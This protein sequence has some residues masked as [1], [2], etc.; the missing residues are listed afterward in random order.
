VVVFHDVTDVRALD[1]VRREFVA[2][3]SHEFRTPLSILHG[4]LETLLDGADSDPAIRQMSLRAMSRSCQRLSLLIDDLLTISRLEGKARILE[5]AACDLR[6]RFSQ[7]LEQ[8]RP[9]LAERQAETHID[10][11]DDASQVEADALRIEQVFLN[12]VGN[13]IRH[14]HCSPLVLRITARRVVDD[15][16]IAV[17]DNGPGIPRADQ[18]LI[19]ERFYR[20]HK[21]RSRSAG[22][23]GLGLSIVKNI[24]QAHGGSVSVESQPGQGTTFVV[25]LP[26]AAPELTSTSR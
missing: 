19:F 18:P 16:V 15:V 3:V 24:V 25:R 9:A 1:N 21:D 10:W 13:A 23:T 14:S 17:S 8:L 22:G 2:N 12:L 7:A 26:V 5:V 6:E 20:V 4:Y 11:P